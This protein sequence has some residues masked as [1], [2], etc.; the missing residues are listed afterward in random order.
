MNAVLIA[1]VVMVS[2]SLSR[3]HVVLSLVIGALVGGV[4]AGLPLA[5]TLTAFQNGVKNGALIALSYAMLGAFAMAI[6]YSGVPNALASAVIN[7]VKHSKNSQIKWLVFFVIVLAAC[8]SQN[9]IPI[10]IAF[11]LLLIPPLLTVFN[12]L[13]IDRRL[14]ACL[15]TFGLVNTYMFIP[16]GFG[17]I[18]LNE[19]IMANVQKSGLATE[20]ISIIKT[21]SIPA[22]GMLVGLLLAVFVSYRKPRSYDNT[23]T[24][25]LNSETT[26]P[27]VTMPEAI[28][29][30]AQNTNMGYKIAVTLVA[31]VVAFGVQLVSDSLILGSMLGFLTFMVTGVVKWSEADN[32]FN[33]GIKMMAMIGFVMISAQGFAEVMNATGHI[34]ALVELA[35]SAFSGNKAVAAFAMLMVGLIVTMGIGS[36]FST[37]P[38]IATIYVPLCMTMGFSPMATIALVATAGVLGDAGS[39]ASDSTL[40]PTMGLN[41]DGQHDHMK[42]TVIPTFIHYNIPLLVFGWIAAMVL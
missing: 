21:M 26:T 13:N 39:P 2:L 8:L 38:I 1:V 27:K 28:T 16:Y 42:D 20:G 35:V 34:E 10:H 32:V 17:D 6:A 25:A 41:V 3:V 33:D 14:V 15:M 37:V 18:Y 11:I 31:I 4:V 19:I 9:L 40:G 24:Q 7:K 36:S 30:V 5:D 29:P 22:L 12:Q 23:K